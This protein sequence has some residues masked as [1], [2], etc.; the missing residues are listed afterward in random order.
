MVGRRWVDREDRDVVL[1]PAVRPQTLQ[2]E[3][4][5]HAPR[6][7]ELLGRRA[8]PAGRLAA[9]REAWE[10]LQAQTELRHQR[11]ERSQAAQQFYC[12]AAEAEAWMGEQELHMMSQE[13]AKVRTPPSPRS[14]GP[15]S[16][17]HSPR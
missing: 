13:K 11:L 7:Q 1:T 15:L 4:Q 12:D 2:K 17:T 3:L 6:V 9:L 5:G 16:S 14:Q 10:E 8:G